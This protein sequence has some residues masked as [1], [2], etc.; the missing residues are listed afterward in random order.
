MRMK[1]MTTQ[2]FALLLIAIIVL[3]VS[4]FFVSRADFKGFAKDWLEI[5]TCSE[6]NITYIE[7]TQVKIGSCLTRLPFVGTT[8]APVVSDAFKIRLENPVS[9]WDCKIRLELQDQDGNVVE[10]YGPDDVEIEGKTIEEVVLRRKR[11]SN[12]WIFCSGT[13]EYDWSNIRNLTVFVLSPSGKTVIANCT[14]TN[15]NFSLGTDVICS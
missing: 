8:V 12:L 4:L 6:V 11:L 10:Y 1:G 13:S 15:V 5:Q 7:S 3:L 9:H 14:L 2:H